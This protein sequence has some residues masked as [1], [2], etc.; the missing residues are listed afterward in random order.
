LASREGAV[1]AWLEAERRP[2]VSVQDVADVFPWSRVAI[3][4]VLS[5]LERK[6]W[7]RRTA[8]GR[9]ETVLAETGGFAPPNPW[10]ALATWAQPHYVALQSA[11]YEHDLTP[12]RPAMVQVAVP[13]GAR[14][15]KAWADVPIALI[16]LRAF[17]QQGVEDD[18][19][20]GVRIRLAT[21]ERV[22]VD[23]AALP[24]RV[25]GPQGLARIATRA[26]PTADWQHVTE[27]A[28][29]RP[30]G[31]AALRRLAATLDLVGTEIP[32][33][34]GAAAAAAAAH[35][36]YLYLGERRLH[37][38]HGRRLRAWAVVDNVGEE[39]LREEIGR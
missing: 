1:V 13:V 12:D 5:H 32:P 22:L 38:A 24:G 19:R 6:G 30:G 27:L 9:Y 18:E 39:T 15:P 35:A 34:L 20:H 33:P 25:G 14:A 8:R 36:S 37:G 21:P 23:A 3:R 16:A 17:S 10:A 29:D 4:D 11:A 26:A 2:V 31:G 7:L 28:Q